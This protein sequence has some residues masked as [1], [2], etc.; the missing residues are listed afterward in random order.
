[1]IFKETNLKGLFEIELNPLKDERGFFARVYD[2]K[3][4]EENGIKRNWVQESVSFSVNKNTLRGLHFQYPPHAEA[5]IVS[6][7]RGEVFFAIV[8][9]KKHSPTFGKW[10]SLILSEENKKLFFAERGFAIGMCT[11][12][13][14]C[15]LHYKMDNFYSAESAETIKWNDPDLNITWPI[16]EPAVISEKD[17]NAKSFKEFLDKTHG[18]EL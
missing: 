12:T 18:I 13:D 7:F 14:N 3:L 8:D 1:M 5:K 10:H 17:K 16:R 11:M 15:L 2:D 9:L 4:F 6:V